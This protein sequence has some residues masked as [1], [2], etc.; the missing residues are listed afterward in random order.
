MYRTR[1]V[2]IL[3]L[4]LSA[5]LVLGASTLAQ[6]NLLENPG[7]EASG[8]SYDGWTVYASGAAISTPADD[9]IYRSG[10]AAAKIYGEFTNCPDF[11]QFDD[12]VVFQNF[13]VT[14]AVEYR[15]SGYTYVSS[16]DT[17]PGTNTCE[18]NRL[19]AKIVFL[20]GSGFEIGGLEMVIGDYSTP[21]DEWVEFSLVAPVP[22]GT[23]SV[24]PRG[25][26]PNMFFP[27][28]EDGP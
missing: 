25:E 17:I 16:A 23:A 18:Y 2:A 27:I 21:R 19:L 26:S 10:A 9:D 15:F 1:T 11:P 6:A 3:S 22:A 12:G 14:S 24:Q 4:V 8:G 7:F 13:P 5:A 20:N 28:F